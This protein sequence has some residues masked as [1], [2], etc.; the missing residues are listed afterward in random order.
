MRQ[1]PMPGRRAPMNRGSG[2]AR[3]SPIKPVRTTP[4]KRPA[5]RAPMPAG[6]AEMVL[7][8]AEWL[9]DWCGRPIMGRPFSRQHRR[10]HGMGGRQGGELHTPANVIVLCGSAT[11]PG[12]HNRAENDERDLAYDL[13]FAIRGEARRPEDVPILRHGL[14]L[15]IPGDGLWLPAEPLAA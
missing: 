4:A 12:C 5:G 8:R 13:G 1:S 2:I 9:C 10:A 14:R 15:V 3:V 7:V 11:S 6:L